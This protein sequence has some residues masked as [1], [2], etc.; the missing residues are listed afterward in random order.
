M[1]DSD[2]PFPYRDYQ[3][4]VLEVKTVLRKSRLWLNL[5][6]AAIVLTP[7]LSGWL[8]YRAAI[9]GIENVILFITFF[10]FL[11]SLAVVYSVEQH[12]K[13][14]RL[15]LDL[16]QKQRDLFLSSALTDPLTGA[17]NRRAFHIA[18]ASAQSLLQ[19]NDLHFALITL[20]IDHFKRI[21]DRYGH[22]GGDRVLA[23]LVRTI[24][25][26]LR[27]SD[28]LARLGGEEFCIICNIPDDKSALRLADKLRDTVKQITLEE[29]L[30][31]DLDLSVS[32]GIHMPAAGEAMKEALK[33]ADQALYQAKAAGRDQ[34]VIFRSAEA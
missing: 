21:N 4:D 29:E 32:L 8:A 20:D 2:Q 27:S 31:S 24:R 28:H 5:V 6:L 3:R 25:S 7:L 15:S 30:D 18:Y 12:Q 9:E 33:R 13:Q 17:L 1:T 23:S 26:V 16:L 10:A 11:I 34:A 22:D 19:R 14:Y